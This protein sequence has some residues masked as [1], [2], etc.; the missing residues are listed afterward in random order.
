MGTEGEMLLTVGGS[1][2]LL[3]GHPMQFNKE[4]ATSSETVTLKDRLC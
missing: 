4:L 3:K 2:L 1:H